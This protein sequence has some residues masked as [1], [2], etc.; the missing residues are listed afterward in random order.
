VSN[1]HDLA[2]V[3]GMVLTLFIMF[4]VNVVLFGQIVAAVRRV[5][6]G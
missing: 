4:G 2:S 1:W 6:A 3:F 5:L